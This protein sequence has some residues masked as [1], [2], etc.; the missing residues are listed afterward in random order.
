MRTPKFIYF[1][2]GNVLLN[3]DHDRGCHQIAEVS[4]LEFETIRAAIFDTD[5][6]AKY[7]C[8]SISSQEFFDQ[9]CEITSASA[10]FRESGLD[11][12]L[13]AA[14]DIFEQN[15]SII[16]ILVDVHRCGIPYGILS[17]TCQAH[18]DFIVQSK[19]VA[20]QNL[21]Q[22]IG[23]SFEMGV[24]KPDAGIYKKAELL[25]DFPP[26]EILFIDD[27]PENVQGALDARWDAIQ[28]TSSHQLAEELR[29]RG[30]IL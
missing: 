14:S 18:W 7:E 1:D 25:C 27:R 23:L 6:Q 10:E 21:F 3:F 8:G 26:E 4:G 11:S 24:A 30:L 19:Y 29:Q 13:R 28:F 17:N 9:F 20:I 12:M 15:S 22:P 2:L 16:S 5:L